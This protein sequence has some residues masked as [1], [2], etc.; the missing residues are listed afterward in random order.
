MLEIQIDEYGGGVPGQAHSELFAGAMEELGLALGFGH[1]VDQLPGATLVT[2]NLV[3]MFGLHRRLRGALVGHLA[4]FE[5]CSVIPM[6][7]YLVAARRVGGL[8]AL[9]RFY[10]VHV[11]VDAHHAALALDHMVAEL[12][13]T[14]PD[15]AAD[16]IFGAAALSRVEAR[17]AR[18]ILRAWDRGDSSLLPSE[19]DTT[20]TSERFYET[21]D[22][23]AGPDAD[24]LVTPDLQ[25]EPDS[26][27]R[28]AAAPEAEHRRGPA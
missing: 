19:P 2:D 5:M 27:R 21:A 23:P 11:E 15:L 17:F 10:E 3:S 24:D 28:S 12:V 22:R 26:G 7:R 16:V 1:Y 14:E 20:T 8:A 6:T 18:S 25:A 9:E 4:L 13:A